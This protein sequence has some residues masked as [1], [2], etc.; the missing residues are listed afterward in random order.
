VASNPP[1]T[2][3]SR[4]L[5]S[6]FE[7]RRARYAW[8]RTADPYRIL[9][10]EVML[11][12]TQAS[13]VEPAFERFIDTFP[14]VTALASAPAGDVLRAWA[15]LGYNRRA[16]ALARAAGTIVR[17]HGGLVP[18]DVDVLRGLPGVGPYTA[19]AVASLAYGQAVAAI[20]TNARRVV[21]R[22]LMGREPHEVP[23]HSIAMLASDVV[24]R[25]DPAGWNQAVMD[26]G[27]EMCRPLPRC[28]SCPLQA[29]C[30]Y[31]RRGI[32]QRRSFRSATQ[33]FEGSTRQLRG[34]IVRELLA[35][36]SLSLASISSATGD[37]IERIAT[38]VAAL[39][40]DGLVRPGPAALAGRPAGRVRLA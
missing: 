33:R 7:P 31:R 14:T 9:V 11:Q 15:G 18:S 13:R 26:L 21:A 6:W 8:R 22:A 2:F 10:S 25:S 39:A 24:D 3:D 17:D 36:P 34:R 4:S 30:R 38:A 20:D 23:A 5:L 37:P 12:Q 28:G 1:P 29:G 35:R 19:A 32:P 27:R 16:V 40:S